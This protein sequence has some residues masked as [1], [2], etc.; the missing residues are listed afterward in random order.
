MSWY[1][2]F[3]LA[4]GSLE[5]LIWRKLYVRLI[6]Y[7]AAMLLLSSTLNWEKHDSTNTLSYWFMALKIALYISSTNFKAIHQYISIIMHL[8]RSIIFLNLEF[9]YITYYFGVIAGNI[10]N[11]IN[12]STTLWNIIVINR[13]F[14][15]TIS[16]CPF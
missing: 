13:I 5:L 10:G 3:P 9:I 8:E 2:I 1:F 11:H 14:S 6:L 12:H 4:E 15:W 7:W 16:V